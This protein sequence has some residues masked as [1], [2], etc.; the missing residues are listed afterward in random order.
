MHPSP[1]QCYFTSNSFN[2]EFVFKCFGFGTI[3]WLTNSYF[4]Y[5]FI[6]HIWIDLKSRQILRHLS[7]IFKTLEITE[8]WSYQICIY[9][10]DMLDSILIARINKNWNNRNYIA[11][12]FTIR[13]VIIITLLKPET[14]SLIFYSYL[15]R[16][17]EKLA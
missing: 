6:C 5:L 2:G 15:K 3:F 1:L 7:G 4:I 13:K 12:I 8:P 10:I 11:N 17:V 9:Y 16:K 14:H